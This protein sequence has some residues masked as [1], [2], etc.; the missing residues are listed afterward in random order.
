MLHKMVCSQLQ[1]LL[2]ADVY[3]DEQSVSSITI[4]SRRVQV[5]D[6]YVALHGTRFDGHEF[7]ASAHQAGASIALIARSSLPAVIAQWPAGRPANLTLLCVDDTLLALGRIAAWQRQ[8]FSGPVLAVTG[9]AGKTSVKQLLTQVL[10]TVYHTCMTQGNLNN[11]IGVP[12]TLLS[13]RT[14]HQAAVIELGAS[15]LGEIAYTANFVQPDVGIITNASHAHLEGFGSL[16]GIVQTKGELIDF[17]S[18]AGTVVL[19]ADDAHIAEWQQRAGNKRVLLFGFSERAD[20]RATQLHCDLNVSRFQLHT[21]Q[22]Q[23]SVVLPLLGEHNV[24][25][26]LAVTAAALSVGI[27]LPQIVTG[28]QQAEAYQGRLQ[29]CLGVAGQRILND[30]YNANPASVM[31]A[32][33]V[34]KHAPSRWLVLGD[35]AELGD[36]SI[37]AHIQVGE[38]AKQQG[39]QHLLACGMSSQHT[40][41]AFGDGGHWFAQQHEM[42]EYLQQQTQAEDVILVKGSRSARM[43]NVVRALQGHGE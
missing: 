38:Y 11:H 42:I 22:G 16:A 14:E 24:R 19:N 13:L 7:V 33:D 6:A 29:W 43:D 3:G 31:A 15:G 17:V 32:I 9:S 40:V 37:R 5:G 8:Q 12:L 10:S 39:I 35:M 20:V 36:D 25:N 21:P 18:P 34:L 23:A 2:N 30:S 27:S 41:N 28:L 26:A 4:D 1:S